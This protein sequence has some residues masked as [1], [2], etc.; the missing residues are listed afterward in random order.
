MWILR[1]NDVDITIPVKE[2]VFF[3]S[4]VNDTELKSTDFDLYYTPAEFEALRLKGILE[5]EDGVTYRF[6]T[7]KG[8]LSNPTEFGNI[9]VECEITVNYVSLTKSMVN[10]TVAAN[11]NPAAQRFNSKYYDMRA[12]INPEGSPYRQLYPVGVDYHDYNTTT[13][14]PWAGW[15]GNEGSFFVAGNLPVFTGG[16]W[17]TMLNSMGWTIN[18]DS[19]IQFPYVAANTIYADG[20]IKMRRARW[21]CDVIWNGEPPH[22]GYENE[23]AYLV[24]G[25]YA[26]IYD[27]QFTAFMDLKDNQ[28]DNIY[29]FDTV[30]KNTFKLETSSSGIKT[31]FGV[32]VPTYNGTKPVS[33]YS[34][35]ITTEGDSPF[36]FSAYIF[37]NSLNGHSIQNANGRQYAIIPLSNLDIINY[38]QCKNNWI[39]IVPDNFLNG[40]VT[41]EMKMTVPTDTRSGG[42]VTIDLQQHFKDNYRGYKK[43]VGNVGD[44]TIKKT[45]FGDY[46]LTNLEFMENFKTKVFDSRAWG[47]NIFGDYNG[48]ISVDNLVDTGYNEDKYNVPVGE[49]APL[50]YTDKYLCLDGTI[51]DLMWN[52]GA[53]INR[54]AQIDIEN[55][56]VDFSKTPTVI[57]DITDYIID[58]RLMLDDDKRTM[59]WSDQNENKYYDVEAPEETGSELYKSEYINANLI[60]AAIDYTSD[61]TPVILTSGC[62]APMKP[63]SDFVTMKDLTILHDFTELASG[64][65]RLIYWNRRQ[66]CM[67]L[68]GKGFFMWWNTSDLTN[69]NIVD[70]DEVHTASELTKGVVMKIILPLYISTSYVNVQTRTFYVLSQ[71]L[72]D[73]GTNEVELLL[74]C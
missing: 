59:Y 42:Y 53:K 44:S 58:E 11:V 14:Y 69:P 13:V 43:I 24:K 15:S 30:F 67:W 38:I 12:F 71:Q 20:E 56:Q 25:E 29:R 6:P 65:A 48:T 46:P 40:E 74:Y 16:E 52:L 7:L 4:T 68:N 21:H 26:G 1:V 47:C 64:D 50:M 8:V 51:Y 27:D 60:K 2:E 63:D 33:Q 37:G 55:N 57:T 41:H 36:S 62:L 35:E 10:L 32:S 19:P 73:D 9:T 22:E 28:E 45:K 18:T 70:N 23:N 31:Y 66:V 39:E 3:V 34:L 49:F 54:I 5:T 61:G 72:A 17:V